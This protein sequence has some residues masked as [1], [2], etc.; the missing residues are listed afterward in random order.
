M[1]LSEALNAALPEIPARRVR[2]ACPKMHPELVWREQIEQG[3]PTI[4]S[5]VP[6]TGLVFRFAPLQWK[7]LQLCD[8]ERSYDEVAELFYQESGEAISPDDIRECCAQLDEVGFWYKSPQERAMTLNA[9]LAEERQKRIM[10][11]SKVG[12]LSTIYVGHW[13]CDR[14]LTWLHI[15]AS[16]VYS[17]WFTWLVLCGFACMIAIFV[18]RWDEIWHDSLRYYNFAEKNGYDLLEFWLL[19]AGIGFFHE[20][21]HGLTCKHFGGAVRKMGF[22]LIYLSPAF[23][24]EV[25]EIYVF[26]GKWQRLAT[27]IAGIYIEM[28]ICTLATFVWWGTSPGTAVHDFAYKVILITGVIVVLVN[29]NPLVKID[30]YYM[31]SELVDVVNLKERS[32]AYVSGWVQRHIFGLPIEVEYVPRRRRW[33]FVPYALLSGLYSYTLLLV[34]ARFTYNILKHYSPEWA[35]VPAAYVAFRIFRSRI[36]TLGRFMQTVY[37]DKRDRVL[38]RLTPPRITGI[39]IGVAVVLFAPIWR[40]TVNGEFVLEPEQRATIRTAV[41]GEVVQVLVD[42]GQ[43]VTAGTS[44]ARLR[45]LSLESSAAQIVVDYH[46]AEA[47]A[48]QSQLRYG[49]YGQAVQ[50]ARKFAE[51]SRASADEIGKLLVTTPVSGVVVTPRPHDL[52]N[53]FLPAGGQVVEVDDL[54]RLRARIYIP[55]FA[56]QKVHENADVRVRPKDFGSSLPGKISSISPGPSELPTAATSQAEYKGLRPPRFFTAELAIENR[57]GLLKDGMSGMAKISAGRRSLAGFAWETVRN[58]A[59][60]KLW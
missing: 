35:F 60:R 40:D 59:Q 45:N 52:T 55:E 48:T 6:G 34:V 24:V 43:Q 21:A 33:L 1:N 3:E 31:F 30:G 18:S 37:L 49:Q 58:F 54:S 28:M 29:V 10:R 36:R 23:F 56:I 26:G 8:G 12:D 7:L 38:A 46:V 53:S 42:E 14:Y 25:A 51:L 44:V 47:R 19:F 2:K 13:N 20:S 4:V 9:K 41:S 50:E 57:E 27:I 11:K 39:A 22:M 17:N 16:F 15:K 32:T 5:S